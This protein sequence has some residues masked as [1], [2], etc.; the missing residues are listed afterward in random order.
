MLCMEIHQCTN[1]DRQQEAGQI[2]RLG[3]EV[4]LQ[5]CEVGARPVRVAP[6]ACRFAEQIERPAFFPAD[7]QKSQLRAE[8]QEKTKHEPGPRRKH[9]NIPL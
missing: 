9:G 4:A 5:T 8:R 2:R 1:V 7:R 3:E 6:Q